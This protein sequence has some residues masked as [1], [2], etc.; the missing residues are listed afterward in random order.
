MLC[1]ILI[2]VHAQG[3]FAHGKHLCMCMLLHH[4]HVHSTWVHMHPS[5]HVA[6]IKSY[7]THQI[8]L[9]APSHV[10]PT[11]PERP[12]ARDGLHSGNAL[13]LDEWVFITKQQACR[14]VTECFVP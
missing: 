13:T 8:M 10:T 2:D 7:C 1:L 4:T 3:V 5:S 11:H 12:S 9:H 14:Q 6:C